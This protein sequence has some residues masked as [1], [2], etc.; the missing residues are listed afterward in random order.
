[1]PAPRLTRNNLWTK[2]AVKYA[3]WKAEVR[4]LGIQIPE[5]GAHIIFYMPMPKSWSKKKK[6]SYDGK[7]HQQV[8]DIDNIAKALLDG[9]YSSDAHIWDIRASKIWAKNG[10][11]EIR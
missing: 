10:G 11:I 7:P 6:L 1:M 5:S 4:A 9:V 3:N 8:P 2:L